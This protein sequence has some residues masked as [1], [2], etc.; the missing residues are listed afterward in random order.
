[1]LVPAVN[2]LNITA[3]SP[4]DC[5]QGYPSLRSR[6]RNPIDILHVHH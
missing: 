6:D 2:L 4:A 3:L 5:G 1:M